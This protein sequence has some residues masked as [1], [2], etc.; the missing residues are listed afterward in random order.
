M[1]ASGSTSGAGFV[2]AWEE[3]RATRDVAIEKTASKQIKF[4]RLR[5]ETT[6]IAENLT[7]MSRQIRILGISVG[8]KMC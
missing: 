3:K 7:F 1:D 4:G 6:N 8:V 2:D 5:I